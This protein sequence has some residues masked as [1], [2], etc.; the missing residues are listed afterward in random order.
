MHGFYRGFGP[1]LAGV[2]PASAVYFWSYETAKT[3][4][5][6]KKLGPAQN[7]IVGCA[8]QLSAGLVFTPVDI[9]KERLQVAQLLKTSLSHVLHYSLP[10]VQTQ[11]L[12]QVL[13]RSLAQAQDR[14]RNTSSSWKEGSDVASFA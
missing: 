3:S 10:R 14:V 11:N 1:T 6:L 8:A 2:V 9:I 7:F 5:L 12:Q 4:I 13:P